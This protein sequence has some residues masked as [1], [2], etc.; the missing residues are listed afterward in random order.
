[1]VHVAAVLGLSSLEGLTLFSTTD[2]LLSNSPILI[3]HGPS[4]TANATHSSWRIQ[5]HVFTLAGFQSYP[6]ITTSPNSPLYAAVKHLP[7]EQ[8]G[9]DIRR[10]L[11]ISLLKYFGDLTDVAKT[12]LIRSPSMKQGIARGHI[13]TIFDES[14]AGNLAGRMVKVDNI[15]EVL[16]DVQAAYNARLLSNIDIDVVLPSDLSMG[17]VGP[18]DDTTADEDLTSRYGAYTPLVKLF[19]SPVFLPTSKF[20]RAPSRPVSRKRNSTLSGEE[21]SSVIREITELFETEERYVSKLEELVDNLVQDLRQKARDQPPGRSG[22]DERSLADLFPI[23][24]DQILDFNS[25]FLEAITET[26]RMVQEEKSI[27]DR[28]DGKDVIVEFS[29][30]LV[31]WFPQF[32]ECYDRYIRSS[33]G[34]PQLLSQLLRDPEST[35]SQR[36]Q[37]FGEQK[38]KSMLIEPVQRLPR[39]NLFIDN[40]IKNLPSNHPATRHLL[41][42]RETVANICA[43]HSSGTEE[44]PAV[45]R[46]RNLVASWPDN[47]RPDGRLIAAVEYLEVPAPYRVDRLNKQ[48]KAN[49]FLIF[50]DHVVSVRKAPDSSLS[51]RGVMAEVD[52]PSTPIAAQAVPGAGQR[53]TPPLIFHEVHRLRDVAFSESGDGSMIFM[54]SKDNAKTKNDGPQLAP[55]SSHSANPSLRAFYLFGPYESRVH[56]W[57]EEIAKAR[58][59]G[60][61]SEQERDSGIWELRSVKLTEPPL[62]IFA[63]ISPE[64]VIDAG[65]SNHSA[66][67]IRLVVNKPDSDTNVGQTGTASLSLEM[68]GK[69]YR[70]KSCFPDG[71]VIVKEVDHADLTR[72][73]AKNLGDLVRSQSEPRDPASA[74]D[75]ISQHLQILRAITIQTEADHSKLRSFKTPSPVKFLSNFLNG[76]TTRDLAGMQQAFQKMG[77]TAPLL[78]PTR[79]TSREGTSKYEVSSERLKSATVFSSRPSNVH[80]GQSLEQ[81]EESMVGYIVALLERRGDIIGNALRERRGA[82]VHQVEEIYQKILED[83]S[84][85]SVLS[86][87]PVQVLFVAF[88]KFLNLAWKSRMGPVV[89]IDIWDSLQDRAC[90][91]L[92]IAFELHFKELIGDMSPQNRRSFKA[93]IKLLADLLEASGN[94]GDRGALTAAFTELLV[95]E[96][97]PHIYISLLDRLVEDFDSFF[98]DDGGKTSEHP[99]K[100]S[101]S[102]NSMKRMRSFNTGS[103]SSNASSLRKRFGFPTLSRE[104]SKIESSSHVES[105]V[106]SV[107]RTLSKTARGAVT[108]GGEGNSNGTA[109]SGHTTTSNSKTISLT[110]SKSTDI[111]YRTMGPP[112]RP[113]SRDRP[114]VLGG[115]FNPIL[116][117]ESSSSPSSRRPQSSSHRM[118]VDYMASGETAEASPTRTPTRALPRRKRRSSLSDLKSLQESP[119]GI[120]VAPSFSPLPRRTPDGSGM[121]N[122]S[123]INS[124]PRTPST[125][126]P[127]M[128][129]NQLQ[130][131]IHRKEQNISSTNSPFMSPAGGRGTLMERATNIQSEEAPPPSSVKKSAGSSQPYTRS[132]SGIPVLK[133]STTTSPTTQR[134]RPT[135]PTTGSATTGSPTKKPNINNTSPQKLRIPNPQKLRT[136]LLTERQTLNQTDASLQAELLKIGQEIGG[137]GGGGSV[138][139][140]PTS[141]SSSSSTTALSNRLKELTTK[142]QTSKAETNERL[143]G[144]QR[145]LDALEKRNTSIEELYRETAAENEVLYERFNDELAKI[146][147][148]VRS[149]GG[150]GGGGEEAGM[151]TLVDKLKDTQVELARLKKENGRLKREVVGLRTVAGFAVGGRSSGGEQR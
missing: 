41:K 136:Q 134:S 150:A 46:L 106:G 67:T 47:L 103:L 140:T 96:G 65:T 88:E 59:E 112:Q 95:P 100:D 1:M 10:G 109:S 118:V 60:R 36:V 26:L 34:L 17:L 62:T 130:R 38:M 16:K 123:T 127:A 50:S 84:K 99:S 54:S 107:W 19:T 115:A 101:G 33:A 11:A 6:R 138:R 94:D 104:N 116:L 68:E 43:L 61:F 144:L 8:Q 86:E 64:S 70:L 125:V 74:A 143:N 139:R 121:Q 108:G 32:T 44:V 83:P 14:Y 53:A 55:H 71:Q 22:L 66:D 73:L 126:K 142:Q 117:E 92:P 29:K 15:A 87:A 12:A 137:G 25:A 82:D 49:I 111:H 42:A 105:K 98:E 145:A 97:D 102:I 2:P 56:R 13:A 77:E 27:H 124:T 30:T 146:S 4:S 113:G 149:G 52:R 128:T 114:T 91:L 37:E 58:I 45:D 135:L 120:V 28:A 81:L 76:G 119:A 75:F 79:K 51:A 35:F 122:Y 20:R 39:Y 69:T 93:I 131:S 72:T 24:L 57:T 148:A 5:A 3:F 151:K 89:S 85:N 132:P 110:R 147:G 21:E 78:P 141:S 133:G 90:T 31:H 23:T 48:Q 80:G 129:G 40:I 9:D 63:T 7:P 18:S